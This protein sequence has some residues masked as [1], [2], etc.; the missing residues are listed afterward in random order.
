MDIVLNKPDLFVY[1]DMLTL[2]KTIFTYPELGNHFSAI[3][4]IHL[5]GAPIYTTGQ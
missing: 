3:M 4:L 2:L 5:Q 1:T